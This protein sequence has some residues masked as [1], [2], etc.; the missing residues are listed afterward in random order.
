MSSALAASLADCQIVWIASYGDLLEQ[1]PPSL[2][3]GLP[4]RRS[5]DSEG[6]Q[7]VL[8]F[9]GISHGRPPETSKY[10]W[11]QLRKIAAESKGYLLTLKPEANGATPDRCKAV[12]CRLAHGVRQL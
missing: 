1:V 5:E 2:A 11:Q 7:Q 8:D 9:I 10:W 3:S 4:W 12:A 6:S